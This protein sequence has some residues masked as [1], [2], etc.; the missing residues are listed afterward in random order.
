[1][2]R[3]L[4]FAQAR[5]LAG[6]A[7]EKWPMRELADTD[8]FWTEALR[9]HPDLAKIRGVCRLAINQQYVDSGSRIESGDEVAVLPP[10][11]GG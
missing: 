6:C 5:E 9:R 3:V 4:Y 10:V 1:M 11:S 2:V 7:E 8:A